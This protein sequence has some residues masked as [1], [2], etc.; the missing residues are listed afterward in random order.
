M[1]SLNDLGLKYKTDRSSENHDYL[2]TYEEY[3]SDIRNNPITFLEI[4]IGFGASVKM[5]QEFFATAKIYGVDI[6]PKQE[7][8]TD[9][10]K[11]FLA[12]QS[13]RESLS[14]VMNKIGQCDVIVD[15]GGHRMIPQQ[16]A[17]GYL[18][19]FVK[20]G[21]LYIIEDLCSSWNVS[22]MRR[23][24]NKDRIKKTTLYI[25]K[26]FCDTGKIDG[27]YILPEETKYLED[28]ILSCD[29]I[30][31]RKSEIAFIRKK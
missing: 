16:V 20:S 5:W 9:R 7:Y 30:K 21:G 1:A 4:G 8:E 17:F 31:C 13:D 29:I 3:L 28:N 14:G 22:K 10:I 11:I 23:L 19:Q 25:L 18:F 6:R 15:D 27:E 24:Y 2:N 12:D 26:T